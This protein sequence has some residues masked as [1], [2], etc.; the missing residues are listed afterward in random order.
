MV[1]LM[2]RYVK[3]TALPMLA[4]L[5]AAPAGSLHAEMHTLTLRQAVERALQQNPDLVIARLEADKAAKQVAV[6][7]D[8]FIP[9]VFVGSGLAYTYG[10]PMTVDQQAPSVIDVTG[11]AAVFDRPRRYRLAEAREEAKSASLSAEEKRE[12]AALRTVEL[13]LEVERA[14]RVAESMRAQAEGLERVVETL[15]L[16][17]EAGRALPVEVKRAELDVAR[18]RRRLEAAEAD[19][20][21]AQARLASV[22]GYPAGD[23]VQAAPEDQ[24]QRAALPLS[25]D[26]AARA[27]VEADIGLRR[28]EASL[29]AKG[30]AIKAEKSE[31]L[32]RMSLVAKYGL[33]AK[34]NNYEEFFRR[35]QRHN[36]QIG[37]AFQVPLFMGSAYKATISQAQIEVRKLQTQLAAARSR[38]DVEARRRFQEVKKA[39]GALELARMELDLAREELDIVLAKMDEGR[40]SIREVEAARFVENQK[41]IAFYEARYALEVARY[42]LLSRTGR[43]L[44]ALR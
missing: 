35:F 20:N 40:A 9:K 24:S 28:L 14:T 10:F 18:A 7:R 3:R 29:R 44:A 4:G 8:P 22:L 34:F 1:K 23:R 38:I 30:L 6:A 19:R 12:E 32:P 26:E 15:R 37:V 31:R 21:Y 5:L 42:R 27:A 39:E 13:F 16:R 33:F 36:A 11:V 2:K 17:A 41:W 25:E 43:L